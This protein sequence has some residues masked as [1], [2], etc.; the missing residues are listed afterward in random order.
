M[1]NK[2]K[3]FTSYQS[4]DDCVEKKDFRKREGKRSESSLK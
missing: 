4:L 3:S 1:S 2:N